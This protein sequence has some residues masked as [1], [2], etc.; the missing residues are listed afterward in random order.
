MAEVA[1]ADKRSPP[2]QEEGGDV[3]TACPSTEALLDF[4]LGKLAPAD[5]DAVADHLEG[6]AACAAA[7]RRL[8]DATDSL[9]AVLRPL[10]AITSTVDRNSPD[11]TGTNAVP[12]EDQPEVPG[13]EVLGLLGRGGMGLVYRARHQTLKRTVALKVIRNAGH[14]DAQ[15]RQRFLGE[16]E[17][18][19]RLSHPNIVQVYEVGEHKGM[20]FLA[21]ELV[22]GGSLADRIGG[23]PLPVAEAVRLVATLAEAIHLAHSRNVVHRDL[24]P[25]NVLLTPDGHPKIADFGIA[26][27]LDCASGQTGT[28]TVLGTPSYMAPEQAAGRVNE[29]GPAADIYALGAILYECL[30]GR[31]PFLGVSVLET[32]DQVRH[33]EPTPP[34]RLNPLVPPDLETICLKCLRKEPDQRY[35]SAH[36]LAADLG[37]F[38]RGEPIAARPLGPWGRLTRW[39]RRYPAVAGLLAALVVLFLAGTAVSTYF[40]VTATQNARTARDNELRAR[41][42]LA[43]G[44]GRPLGFD[45]GAL[46][47]AEVAILWELSGTDEEVRLLFFSEALRQPDTA[48]CLARRANVAVQAAVCLDSARRQRVRELLLGTLRDRNA[49]L[50]VREACVALG[51]A[52]ALADADFAAEMAGVVLERMGRK[53]DPPALLEQSRAVA[54]RVT[55][56]GTAEAAEVSGPVALLVVG[57]LSEAAHPAARNFLARALTA[58]APSLD[59]ASAARAL[60]AIL[61]I[62]DRGSE[63]ASL[64]ALAEACAALAGRLS[65]A[66][67]EALAGPA[68]RVLLPLLPPP[69]LEPARWRLTQTLAALASRLGPGA[70]VTA[71]RRLDEA[72]APAIDL[73]VLSSRLEVTA[74]LADRLEDGAARAAATALLP[75]VLGCLRAQPEQMVPSPGLVLLYQPLAAR[76][77]PATAG[78]AARQALGVLKEAAEPDAAWTCTLLLVPLADRL[79]AADAAALGAA[80]AQAILGQLERRDAPPDFRARALEKLAPR[81]RAAEVSELAR[82]LL[83]VLAIEPHPDKLMPAFQSLTA[84]LLPEEAIRLNGDA[85]RLLAGHIRQGPRGAAV[86]RWAELLSNL[87]EGLPPADAVG[88]TTQAVNDLLGRM[89]QDALPGAEGRE[90]RA[91]GALA[92]RLP[93]P[94]TAVALGKVLDRLSL[95]AE[96]ADVAAA[97]AS[98]AGRLDAEQARA[99]AQRP[100]GLLAREKRVAP[101]ARMAA[102]LTARLPPAEAAALCDPVVRGLL[103]RLRRANDPVEQTDEAE[104]ID[105]L[106]ARLEADAS[107]EVAFATAQALLTETVRTAQGPTVTALAGVLAALTARVGTQQATDLLKQPLCIGPYREAVLRDLSRRAGRPFADVWEFAIWARQQGTDLETPPRYPQP[108]PEPTWQPPPFPS[109]QP[110]W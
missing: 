11:G 10:A 101:L 7:L 6:C 106:A 73:R 27:R 36:E 54:A 33:R 72:L 103:E 64:P 16:A 42:A 9:L 22:E 51:Q 58:L 71:A 57:R 60:E 69:A 25:A 110:H 55:S 20:P 31:P 15:A 39:A 40:G 2:G 82:R 84:R 86:D 81:L 104:A 34:A 5:I 63:P 80:A 105:V 90:V 18:A 8:D 53:A 47:P 94:A 45:G 19:A 83:P 49:D 48:A 108:P 41:A 75:R 37:R 28:G 35:P 88:L 62:L 98:L 59:A 79:A 66:Q 102:A 17:V 85:A 107:T 32:L 43:R 4:H 77:E 95:P 50:G 1:R 44:L 89:A 99:A 12:E 87:A 56:F 68:F 96:R 29:V 78:P 46:Q 23:R 70:A 3:P 76:L 61:G 91:V 67:A 93:A 74:A 26:R 52:L 24:K 65:L 14:T 21:L 92:K 38:S 109:R 97:V 30:T 100:L 13:Y